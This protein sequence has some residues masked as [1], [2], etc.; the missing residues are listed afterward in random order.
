[1]AHLDAPGMGTLG[2][3]APFLGQSVADAIDELDE[4]QA[5]FDQKQNGG[6]PPPL[7]SSSALDAPQ[8]QAAPGATTAMPMG[9]PTQPTPPPPLLNAGPPLAR[10]PGYDVPGSGY[11]TGS[12]TRGSVTLLAAIA[13]SAA[14]GL[15][16]QDPKGAVVG[17]LGAGALANLYHGKSGASSPD[18][19]VKTD[20]LVTGVISLVGLCAAAYLG[21]G[22][23]KEKRTK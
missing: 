13:T 3:D 10:P 7:L 22:L 6:G 15:Y 17:F 4:A 18:P 20:A 19:A 14:L 2:G 23:Y 9:P 8:Q 12:R 5:R 16:T 11:S 1:M 21:Y